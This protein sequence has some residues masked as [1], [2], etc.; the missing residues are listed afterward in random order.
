MLSGNFAE[1][2]TSKAFRD[3]LRNIFSKNYFT[4]TPLVYAPGCLRRTFGAKAH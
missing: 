4:A 2:T 3:V 1:M